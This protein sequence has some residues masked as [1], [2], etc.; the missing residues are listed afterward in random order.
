[1]LPENLF[2]TGTRL[3]AEGGCVAKGKASSEK[4]ARQAKGNKKNMRVATCTQLTGALLL[5]MHAGVVSAAP[6]SLAD[7]AGIAEDSQR[8][9]C[10][11]ALA[12]AQRDKGANAQAGTQHPPGVGPEAPAGAALERPEEKPEDKPENKSGSYLAK[13]WELE[14]D[15]K[16]GTF[17]FQ[18]H[19]PNYLLATYSTSPN[20]APYQPLR[21]FVLSDADLSHAEVVFQL[22]FKM[23]VLQEVAG[24]PVDLW[25]GYTQ[26]SFWQA[27][28]RKASSPFRETNYQPEVMAVLP[29]NVNLLGLRARFVNLGIVHQSNGQASTLSRSWDRVY[30]QVGLERGDFTLV[31]RIWHRRPEN[32]TSDDNPDI[33]DY[34]G[35][36]DLT[37]TYRWRGHE[38]SLQT[39]YNVSTDKGSAQ[40][41]WA[42]PMTEH[43]KGYVQLF[44][45]YGNS[46]IDYNH[47]QNTFGLGVLVSY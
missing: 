30:A 25:V 11:D 45:G 2:G 26:Q 47:A 28:N 8:L 15:T 43:V 5:A 24:S 38:F 32:L 16:R 31:G 35:R 7:C 14:P 10:F 34:M 4:C 29:L 12:A 33:I 21:R 9:A 20:S 36:G 39:R 19:Q 1:V 27:G 42:F 46:L 13:H 22:G 41:G 44:S 6:A 18:S 17:K 37:G 40:L 23:K 3:M